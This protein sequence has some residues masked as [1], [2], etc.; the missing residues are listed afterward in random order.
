[1]L[2]YNLFDVLQADLHS[3]MILFSVQDLHP[4]VGHTVPVRPGTS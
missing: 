1:M 3:L 4:Y 2:Y